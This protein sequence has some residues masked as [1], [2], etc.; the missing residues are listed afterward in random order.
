MKPSL[1]SF[2]VQA[3]NTTGSLILPSVTQKFAKK[4]ATLCGCASCEYLPRIRSTGPVRTLPCRLV[5]HENLSK[6]LNIN[7]RMPRRHGNNNYQSFENFEIEHG[8]EGEVEKFQTLTENVSR[9]RQI[10]NYAL[11][12]V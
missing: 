11:H 7:S 8:I 6:L 2:W 1:Y 4:S 3:R 5:R 9:S 10:F 12:N